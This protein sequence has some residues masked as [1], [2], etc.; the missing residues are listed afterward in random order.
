MHSLCKVSCQETVPKLLTDINGHMLMTVKLGLQ[1]I[2]KQNNNKKQTQHYLKQP[3]LPPEKVITHFQTI[4]HH[5][6]MNWTRPLSQTIN[7]TYWIPSINHDPYCLF[8]IH[9]SLKYFQGWGL[10]L[11]NLFKCLTALSMERLF[12]ISSLN[13]PLC[14]LRSLMKQNYSVYILSTTHKHERKENTSINRKKNSLIPV[15]LQSCRD[16]EHV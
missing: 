15:F 5:S 10:Y 6:V 14:N 4:H 7:L 3:F 2:K 16:I 9:M 12:L 13:I 11:G 1:V 8:K